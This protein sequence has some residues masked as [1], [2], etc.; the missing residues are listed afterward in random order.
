MN[1]IPNI[2]IPDLDRNIFW[3]AFKFGTEMAMW[4]YLKLNSTRE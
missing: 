4:K 1:G 3:L 2:R